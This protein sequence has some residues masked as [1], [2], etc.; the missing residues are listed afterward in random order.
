LRLLDLVRLRVKDLS[1]ER[2]QLLFRDGKGR[3]DRVT[4]V[5]EILSAGLRDQLAR[6]PDL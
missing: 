2:R 4:M 6:S 3:K 5:P 1:L